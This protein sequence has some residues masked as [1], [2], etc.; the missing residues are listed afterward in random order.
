MDQRLDLATV[1]LRD[2]GRVCGARGRLGRGDVRLLAGK[3]R[4]GDH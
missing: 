1:N 4:Q 3:V 2:L